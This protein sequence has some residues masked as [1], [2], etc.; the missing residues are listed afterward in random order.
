MG[1]IP[2]DSQFSIAIV[3]S[4]GDDLVVGRLDGDYAEAAG[5]TI[6]YNSPAAETGV[7]LPA[8]GQAR[9]P[10]DAERSISGKCNL[11]SHDHDISIG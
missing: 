8:R 11:I 1:K 3:D 2:T 6:N 10:R 5:D 9:Q 7:E 4:N